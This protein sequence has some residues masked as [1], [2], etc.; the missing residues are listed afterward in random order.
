MSLL[1]KRLPMVQ[2][3][4]VLESLRER[5]TEYDTFMYPLAGNCD[6]KNLAKIMKFTSE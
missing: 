2:S 3:F 1:G 5:Y 6:V 4:L